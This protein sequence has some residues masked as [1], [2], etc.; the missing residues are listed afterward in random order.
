MKYIETIKEILLHW[1]EQLVVLT[2]NIIVGILV[3]FLTYHISTFLSE[4][5]LKIIQRSFPKS[6]Q[7]HS[8]IIL[9]KVLRFIIIL[10]GVFIALEVMHLG[11]FLTK[12]LGSLGVAGIIAGVALKDLVSSMFSGFLVGADKSFK[13]GDNVTINNVNGTVEDIGFLT[14]KLLT[15][16][17]IRISIPNQLIFTAPFTNYS[18]SDK[19]KAIVTLETSSTENL[20][21]IKEILTDEM[22]KNKYIKANEDIDVVFTKQSLGIFILEVRFWISNSENID[23]VKSDTMIAL[24]DRLK[25]EGITFIPPKL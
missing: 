13:K 12:L 24:H 4:W 6:R 15:S 9:V 7:T 14:T 16:D 10:A 23:D 5:L 17:G 22:K 3:V 2:P 25:T 11:G 18:D 19:R 20:E 21:K 8:A 1:W